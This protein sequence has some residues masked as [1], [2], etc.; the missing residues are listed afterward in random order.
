[1]ILPVYLWCGRIIQHII[2]KCWII[3]KC[4]I[5]NTCCVN[6]RLLVV[7]YW[8]ITTRAIYCTVCALYQTILSRS[9]LYHVEIVGNYLPLDS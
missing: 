3:D 8:T 6:S 2:Q 1:M 4:M 7:R 5:N 9:I